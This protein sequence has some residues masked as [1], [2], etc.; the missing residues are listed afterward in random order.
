MKKSFFIKLFLVVLLAGVLLPSLILERLAVPLMEPFLQRLNH[1]YVATSAKTLS[2]WLARQ[3]DEPEAELTRIATQYP[4]PVALIAET[5][6]SLST[7]EQ[8]QLK[9]GDMIYRD[10]SQRF[11]IAIPDTD[12]LL[13][14]GNPSKELINIATAAEAESQGTLALLQSHFHGLPQS[15]WLEK[16]EQLQAFFPYPL[17][18]VTLSEL[19]LSE[20]KST[21]TA[22]SSALSEH[23]VLNLQQIEKLKRGEIVAL[24]KQQD[25]INYGSS[26]N[27][28]M[29]RVGVATADPSI[30]VA[31][32]ITPRINQELDRYLILNQGSL[33]ALVLILL[34]IWLLPT[35]R[36]SHSLTQSAKLFAAGSRNK[37]ATKH[38]LSHFHPVTD[39]F[40]HMAD[41]IEA[42]FRA[43]QK[44][45]QTLSQD[46]ETSI[47]SLESNLNQLDTQLN[48][49]SKTASDA[50]SEQEITAAIEYHTEKLTALTSAALLEARQGQTDIQ[51]KQLDNAEHSNTK[52]DNS[53]DS[54]QHPI[55]S[56]EEKGQGAKR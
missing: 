30:I 44:L 40:N 19:T 46:I 16:V 25:L 45:I 24:T 29:Q 7:G 39:T 48:A 10:S 21:E 26:L 11:I 36:A 31:G 13:T 22:R 6:L 56:G 23:P 28:F 32:P 43:N 8:R 53:E 47:V 18:L 50:L 35:W 12:Q 27:F 1:Y 5:E 34:I 33:A 4:I 20:L 41:E 38:R 17:R 54:A 37:R 52:Q 15:Q 9:A 42:D 55:K 51:T 3:S 14:L 49:K 2:H